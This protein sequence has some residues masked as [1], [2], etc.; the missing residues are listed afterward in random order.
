L[1]SIQIQ[2]FQ[3]KI[4]RMYQNNKHVKLHLQQDRVDTI[5]VSD[6]LE[7]RVPKWYTSHFPSFQWEIFNHA[8]RNQLIHQMQS[9]QTLHLL[10]Q[11]T[12][13]ATRLQRQ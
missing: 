1:S 8:S 3:I 13:N 10:S 4:I 6:E 12:T 7:S 2:A 11:R 5:F 9:L